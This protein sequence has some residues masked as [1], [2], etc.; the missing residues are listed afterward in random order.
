MTRLSALLSVLA[1]ATALACLIVGVDPSFAQDMNSARETRPGG[2]AGYLS[3]DKLPDSVNERVTAH[4]RSVSTPRIS[5]L[6]AFAM[7]VSAFGPR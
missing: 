4:S 5:A 3:T 6:P 2:V 1:P 7:I